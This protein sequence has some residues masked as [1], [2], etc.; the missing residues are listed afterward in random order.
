[1]KEWAFING[2]ARCGL[3]CEERRRTRKR[4]AEL[5]GPTV[6]RTEIEYPPMSDAN[7]DELCQKAQALLDEGNFAEAIPLFQQAVEA[8]ADCIAAHEGLALA[9]SLSS[10]WA[11][12]EKHFAK[13]IQLEPMQPR[14]YVNLGTLY[15]R[16]GDYPKAVDALRRALQR[17]RKNVPGYFSLGLA[18]RKLKQ[19][20]MSV[21]AYKEAIRLSPEFAEAYLNLANV[22]VDMGNMGQAVQMFKKAIELKPDFAKARRGLEK[23]QGSI[24]QAK[25]A[26]SPFGRLVGAERRAKSVP[27]MERELSDE[28]RGADRKQIRLLTEALEQL[29]KEALQL[30]EQVL[31]RKLHELHVTITS[32]DMGSQ[33]TRDSREFRAA[34]ERWNDI[35][36][37]IRR[38]MLEL[39][40][41]EELMIAPEVELN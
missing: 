17:D 4:N 20:A 14:H 31:E 37:Q 18:Y 23:A 21:S 32:N 16:K 26:E 36:Q 13:L 22:F 19:A 15:N 29:T 11:S 6:G 33:L 2:S 41:H 27:T 28:E 35:R 7:I 34:V 8:D 24:A 10:D 30:L 9:F 25:K 5:I 3:I 40:A 38:K 39:R 12:G 1:M